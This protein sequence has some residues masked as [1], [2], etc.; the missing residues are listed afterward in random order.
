VAWI[1]SLPSSMKFDFCSHP[2][3]VELSVIKRV[4]LPFLSW[5]VRMSIHRVMIAARCL[6][7]LLDA[8][9]FKL[10]GR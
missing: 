4:Q 7:R 3:D 9:N 10:L 2:S 6:S 1:G 8:L 5:P